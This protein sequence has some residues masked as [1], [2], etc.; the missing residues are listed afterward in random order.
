[1][2]DNAT[3]DAAFLDGIDSRIAERI[4][5]TLQCDRRDIVDVAPVSAGLTNKSFRFSGAGEAE[6]ADAEE[7]NAE[8]AGIDAADEDAPAAAHTNTS[9]PTYRASG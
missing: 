4:C 7:N 8:V 3:F 9:M 5:A 6:V 1:M 2:G